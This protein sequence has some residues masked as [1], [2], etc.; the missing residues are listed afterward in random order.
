[1]N[2]SKRGYRL[3]DHIL[4]RYMPGATEAEREDARANLKGLV[5][6]LVRIDERLALDAVEK[7][8]RHPKQGEVDSDST[9][10]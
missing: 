8:I 9:R 5:R 4:D 7:S 1:M 3:G 6:I 10:L 2:H